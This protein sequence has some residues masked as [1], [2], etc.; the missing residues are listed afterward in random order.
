[1]MRPQYFIGQ[2]ILY[3]LFAGGVGYLSTSPVYS[4]IEPDQ[5]VIK[6][7]FSHVGKRTGECRP[8]SPQE[9]A[10]LPPNMRHTLDCPRGRLPVLVELE[11]DGELLIRRS[12]QASGL[13]HDRASSIYQKVRVPPGHHRLTARLRDSAR[14]EGFD[15]E[16][17]AEI[18]LAPQQNFVVDFHAE[19][20][21]FVF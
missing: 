6:L 8:M 21:G 18:T 3:A 12:L 19:N 16:R 20:G 14:T 13:S 4:P 7:S 5:A 11:M 17:S 1:M 2:A 10:Q 9:I 15:Y